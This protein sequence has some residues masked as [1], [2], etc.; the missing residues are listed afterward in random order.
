[1]QLLYTFLSENRQ[2]YTVIVQ[3]SILKKNRKNYTVYITS[4]EPWNRCSYSCYTIS[5]S[6][7]FYCTSPLF[8]DRDNFILCCTIFSLETDVAVLTLRQRHRILYAVSLPN[9]PSLITRIAKSDLDEGNVAQGPEPSS[10]AR[11]AA[12]SPSHSLLSSWRCRWERTLVGR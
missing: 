9:L 12:C 1:M 11:C 10:S 6:S 7:Y 5:W 3:F 4:L 2:S 8:A